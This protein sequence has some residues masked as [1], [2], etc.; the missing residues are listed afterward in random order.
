MVSFKF[1]TAQ[2]IIATVMTIAII[3]LIGAAVP[4]IR[5]VPVVG[6]VFT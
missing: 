1:P 5:N 2:M 6:S 4:A 3:K